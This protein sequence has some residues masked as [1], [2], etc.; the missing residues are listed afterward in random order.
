MFLFYCHMWQIWQIRLA[1]MISLKQTLKGKF[2]ENDR[3]GKTDLG[4]LREYMNAQ[5]F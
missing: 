2:V 4:V 5:I 3:G 1:C